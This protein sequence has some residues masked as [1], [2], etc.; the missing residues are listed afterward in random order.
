MRATT[1]ISLVLALVLAGMAAFGARLWLNTERAQLA[2]E[3][4]RPVQVELE[5]KNTIV[6]AKVVLQFGQRLTR[7][8][9]EE[10][11]WA[12]SEL[13]KGTFSSM[14]QLV[15]NDE[16]AARF[17]VSS[18]EIGE[19]IFAANITQPGQRAKLSTALTPGMKAAAIRVNDVLGVAGFV[20]P[21]DR[22]DIMLTQDSGGKAFVDVLLQGVKVLA[23]DQIADDRKDQPSVVRTVTFEVSTEEAQKL[24]LAASVGRLSLALRNI[25]SAETESLRRVTIQDLVDPKVAEDLRLQQARALAEAENTESEAEVMPDQV[26][27]LLK[28]FMEEISGR[29]DGVETSID[30]ANSVTEVPKPVAVA[31]IALA[32]PKPTTATVGVIRG[33]KR[34]DYRVPVVEAIEAEP[35]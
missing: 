4:S 9:L 17:V 11:E 2:S 1:V 28:G 10:I 18:I 34:S 33:G 19:P 20:L 24:A 27:S 35:R 22:V 31:P 12:A 13:P 21:G 25:G 8:K 16:E 6:V 23:I 30:E 15:S 7:D 32:P 5:E 26:E 3:A 29:L 14:D